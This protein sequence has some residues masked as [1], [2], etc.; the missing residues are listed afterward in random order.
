[1]EIKEH[2]TN[3]IRIAEIISDEVLIQDTESALDLLGNVYYQGF[4]KIILH[5]ENIIP[6][7]FDLKTK[8]AGDILQ[9]FA[10]YRMPIGI[11]GDFSK[12]QSNSLKE[13]IY[14]TNKVGHNYFG[15][16]REG[17]LQHFANTGR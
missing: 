10:Q 11:I 1:M 17:A 5:Q 14:E 8:I 4:D 15:G 9:K 6:S 7:F 3:D 16:S 12:Y 13:F 2:N